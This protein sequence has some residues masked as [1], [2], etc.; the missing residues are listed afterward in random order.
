VL[1]DQ[2]KSLDWQA[3]KVDFIGQVP[4]AVVKEVLAKLN[5]LLR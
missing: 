3:R 5:T 2:V 4:D 1:S